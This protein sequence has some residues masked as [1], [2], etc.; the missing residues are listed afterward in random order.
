[1]N[2]EQRVEVWVS[3]MLVGYMF[4]DLWIENQLVVECKALSHQ[5][6]NDEVYQA[7]SYLAATGTDVGMIY[8]FGRSRLDYHRIDRK[9]VV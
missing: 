4:L 6:T 7:V 2:P 9:S 3:D 8:N 5:L 1:M